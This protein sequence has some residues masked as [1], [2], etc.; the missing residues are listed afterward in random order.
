MFGIDHCGTFRCE[1]TAGHRQR[2]ALRREAARDHSPYIDESPDRNE[3]PETLDDHHGIEPASSENAAVG[4]SGPSSASRTGS[5]AASET[6]RGPLWPF[7]SVA[8]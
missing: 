3:A 1:A 6:V 5:C 2:R 4:P 7:K 8:V